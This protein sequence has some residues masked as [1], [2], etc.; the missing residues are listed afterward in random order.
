MPRAW[1]GSRF[2]NFDQ[3]VPDAGS[4]WTPLQHL[5]STQYI[6]DRLLL[7]LPKA[8]RF[9]IFLLGS[10]GVPLH[11]LCIYRTDIHTLRML[12]LLETRALFNQ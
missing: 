5:P 10:V 7:P 4:F 12:V 3:H 9:F 2:W 11:L 1:L 8:L 6:L